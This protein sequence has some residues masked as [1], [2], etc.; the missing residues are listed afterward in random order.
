MK[1]KLRGGRTRGKYRERGN[2]GRECERVREEKVREERKGCNEGEV[3]R[4]TEREST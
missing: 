4:K 3:K 2:E 1:G